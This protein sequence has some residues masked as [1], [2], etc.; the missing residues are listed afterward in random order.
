MAGYLFELRE[1][2]SPA[3][4]DADPIHS[5]VAYLRSN[6]VAFAAAVVA[7]AAAAAV[8]VEVLNCW[9]CTDAIARETPRIGSMGCSQNGSSLAM[10]VGTL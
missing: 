6:V 2:P 4:V 5:F 10:A 8:V 7:A 9:G 3:A 1:T